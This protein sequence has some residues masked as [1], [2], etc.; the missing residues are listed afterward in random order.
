MT[1]KQK[2]QWQADF[3]DYYIQAHGKALE[4][5]YQFVADQVSVATKG[6]ISISRFVA[7]A[8]DPNRDEAHRYMLVDGV[9]LEE[10]PNFSD[11]QLCSK[12]IAELNRNQRMRLGFTINPT[13]AELIR[14]VKQIKLNSL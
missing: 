10:H 2:R 7:A 4:V 3:Q 6:K 1:R 9:P 11:W 14:A 13:L 5:E 12:E 8:I